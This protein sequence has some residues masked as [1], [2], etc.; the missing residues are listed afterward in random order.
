MTTIY[1]G[2]TVADVYRQ[3][4]VDLLKAPEIVVWGNRTT[5]EILNVVT[6]L[7]TPRH[8]VQIIPGRYMNPWLALSEAIWLLAG[9]NDIAALEPYNKRIKNYS[10]DGSTLYGAYGYRIA[11]QI[12]AL[13]YRL[14]ENPSDRRA[15]LS[16]WR[17][18]DLMAE[19]KDPPC[20]DMVM[21]KLRDEKLHMT[22]LNRSNDL[23][24]GLY[25][26][27]GL[28]FSILQE[29]LASRLG[30]GMG[31]QTHVSNSLHI[32]MEGPGRAITDRMLEA[33]DDPIE[34]LTSAHLFSSVA[35]LPSH[36]IFQNSCSQVL[37]GTYKGDLPFLIFSQD[38]LA[39]YA[40]GD[41]TLN[42]IQYGKIFT[43]WMVA[44][45]EF[46]DRIG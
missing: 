6:E 32:Y 24:W 17:P 34:R 10:D 44:G 29:Y 25:A 26:V 8:R 38:Y 45:E 2:E 28:Q 41:K 4:L 39:Y 37:D 23:H 22:V 46:L 40:D 30:V 36:E 16:I 14:Q 18:E 13:V 9:R 15:V 19:T 35:D 43:D 20:N 11:A 12:P 7:T 1:K 21:F 33:M 31:T 42:R 3:Q 27:N 5:R